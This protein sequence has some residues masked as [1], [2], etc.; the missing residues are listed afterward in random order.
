MIRED[1]STTKLRIVFDASAKRKGPSLNDCLYSGPSL[2]A[3]LFSVLM[4]F[5]EGNVAIVADV[6]KA[7]LQISLDPEH[8]DYVRFLWFKDPNNIDFNNFGNNELIH[9]R[10]CRVLFGVTS[11]PFLLMRR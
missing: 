10:L 5:R 6:E 4:K 3:S 8:R 9:Y 7:F 11:S 1:K 2:T